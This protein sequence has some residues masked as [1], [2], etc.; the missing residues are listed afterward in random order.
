MKYGKLLVCFLFFIA[1]FIG[2]EVDAS[3]IDAPT[4]VETKT[5]RDIDGIRNSY[6]KGLTVANSEVLVYIDGKFVDLADVSNKNSETESFFY[7]FPNTILADGKNLAVVSR[8]KTSLVLSSP[9]EIELSIAELPAPTLISPNDNFVSGLQRPNITGLSV[10]NT[11]VQV[12]IDGKYNGKTEILRHESGTANFVYRPYLNLK[13]G[14]HFVSLVSETKE[15]Q[16]SKETE[17]FYFNIEEAMPAPIIVLPEEDKN[18]DA[19]PLIAGLS[20]NNSKIKIFLD[21][22]LVKTIDAIDNLSGT[23]NFNYEV[24]GSLKRGNHLVYVTALDPRGKESMWSN[25]VYFTV[26]SPKISVA[27]ETDTSLSE[28]TNKLSAVVVDNEKEV[29]QCSPN[30]CENDS[31][32]EKLT[33]TN[34]NDEDLKEVVKVG[35]ELE[36]E[37]KSILDINKDISDEDIK[38]LLEE[39]TSTSMEQSGLVNENNK[40]TSKLNWNLVVFIA[41]LFG[42]ISWI[43]WVNKELIKERNE[44]KNDTE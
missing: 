37:E 26:R 16:V 14:S 7:S 4:I 3:V 23:A 36:N 40:S 11:Y 27:A 15:G 17:L 24:E 34:K 32:E 9:V 20:K 2:I 22:E 13:I 31:S 5:A 21:H 35:D 41:F 12:Y 29:G 1:F 19:T 6:I 25:I 42:V 44:K 8:D 43:F 18:S 39:E 38:K 28:A 10:S 30:Q 33:E